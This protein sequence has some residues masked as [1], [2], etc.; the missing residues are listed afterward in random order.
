MLLMKK[1]IIVTDI[2]MLNGN[3]Y[4]IN[5]VY[6]KEYFPIGLYY[7]KSIQE[8]EADEA[9]LNA[10]W[11]NN[12]IPAQRDSIRRGL[13]CIGIT[14]V[15]ELK[16]L[17]HGV[18]LLNDYWIKEESEN[19]KWEDVNFWDNPFSKEI[20][21]ALFNHKPYHS[22]YSTIGVSPDG[23][24][25]GLLKKKWIILD[26]EYYLQKSGSGLTKEEVFH[27]ILGTE[28]M[29]AAHI[30]NAQYQIHF[31]DKEACCISKC[32]TSKNTEFIPF[33]QIID[34]VERRVYPA[35]SEM[36]HIKKILRHFHVKDYEEYLNNLLCIDYILANTDRHYNNLALL[37][38]QDT[39]TFSFSP[40]YD[41]GNC[42]WNGISTQNIDCRDD[43]IM[44]RPFCNKNTFGTWSKQKEFIASYI[45]LRK[46]DLENALHHYVSLTK[47]YS[48]LTKQRICTISSGCYERAYS[49]QCYLKEKN[50]HI[51]EECI[52]TEED[53]ARFRY[54]V[55]NNLEKG[56]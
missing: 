42:L 29:N 27:E 6:N 16:I 53:I 24:L 40:V 18:S 12:S 17:S 37:Y 34:V 45:S 46:E 39:D 19:L 49:L 25:N 38:H 33:T 1:D 44:A 28:L 31:D 10:W 36:E 48:E 50:I 4:K 15:E 20:G 35:E 52:I 22:D 11:K 23:S 21:E 8:I 55:Q 26:G 30:P 54:E 43:S 51:S 7:N 5:Q 2:N 47:Q 41:T 3:I 14:S 9:P 56:Q 13:E 32:F